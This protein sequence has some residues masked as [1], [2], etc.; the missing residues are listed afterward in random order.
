MSCRYF[1][2]KAVERTV[3][4][5]LRGDAMGQYPVFWMDMADG[6]SEFS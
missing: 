6:H 1:A 4:D 3:G 5:E 2:T